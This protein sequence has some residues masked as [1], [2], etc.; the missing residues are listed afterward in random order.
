MIRAFGQLAARASKGGG[1]HR[2]SLASIDPAPDGVIHT[3]KGHQTA[4]GVAHCY[5][6]LNIQRFCLGQRALGDTIGFF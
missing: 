2:F 6:D 4:S 5:I 1:S 3:L